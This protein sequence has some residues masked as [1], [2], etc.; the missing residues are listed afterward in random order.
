MGVRRFALCLFCSSI[1]DGFGSVGEALL[2][3][4]NHLALSD[5]GRSG[6][7]GTDRRASRVGPVENRGKGEG[8]GEELKNGERAFAP[9]PGDSFGPIQA[10]NPRML[11]FVNAS[12]ERSMSQSTFS[13]T[14]SAPAISKQ[15]FRES[16]LA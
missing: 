7:F 15:L 2:D 14:I 5:T 12:G 13:F 9:L 3:C 11:S 16:G 6:P 8:G 10:I 4:R 1:Y